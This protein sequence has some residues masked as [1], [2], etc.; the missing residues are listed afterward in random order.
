MPNLQGFATLINKKESSI[1]SAEGWLVVSL[2]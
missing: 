1:L 2:V